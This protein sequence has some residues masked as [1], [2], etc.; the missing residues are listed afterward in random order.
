M[1]KVG[2]TGGIGSGKSTV[3]EIF[4]R[5]GVPVLDADVIAHQLTTTGQSAV[6]K[7]ACCLGDDVLQADGSLNRGK[8]R[9]LV[10]SNPAKK[11]Q[12][13][14]ILHPL[15]Y[16]QLQIQSA[17]VNYPYCI[18]SIPLLIE[19]HKTD[20]VDRILVVDCPEFMQLARVQQRSQL[21]HAQITAM[22]TSQVSRTRRLEIAHDI[23]DNSKQ[24]ASLLEPIDKLHTFYL[25]LSST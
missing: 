16:A 20:F 11:Q 2:L 18:L 5:Y 8:V 10:F 22:M 25:Q 13:E 9:E 19:T 15:I 23:L 3:A 7:I 14:A 17:Q 6:K 21:T 4:A 1:L 12:L 24:T